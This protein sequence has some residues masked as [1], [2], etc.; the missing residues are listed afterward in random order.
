MKGGVYG[1]APNLRALDNNGAVVAANDFPSVCSPPMKVDT[2][3]LFG[4]EEVAGTAP[5]FEESGDDRQVN[6]S[7]WALTGN[8]T[9]PADLTR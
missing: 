9:G 8:A 7:D 5:R 1:G 6:V 2:A 3:D 4:R